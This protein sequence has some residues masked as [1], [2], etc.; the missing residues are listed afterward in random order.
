MRGIE[1]C[2]SPG[3]PTV[4]RSHHPSRTGGLARA[5]RGVG[6]A[7]LVVV[8]AIPAGAQSSSDVPE[9]YRPPPGM[10]R[11]WIEGVPASRQP[12]PTDCPSAIRNRPPN[13]RVIF[14]EQPAA[15]QPRGLR[16]SERPDTA[17]SRREKKPK[18]SAER[19][20]VDEARR[21]LERRRKP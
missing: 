3:D 18:E 8:L 5:A 9:R 17:K 10:C 4:H 7:G 15:V 21:L 11:V 14:G 2:R 16:P 13:A 1:G 20:V 19:A 12:A 6:A